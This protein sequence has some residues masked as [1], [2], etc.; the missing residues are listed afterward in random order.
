[1]LMNNIYQFLIYF[2]I[3]EHQNS[4]L[5]DPFLKRC[6]QRIIPKDV[7]QS[8]VEPDLTRFGA[9]VAGPIWYYFINVLREAFTCKYPRSANKN[10]SLTVFFALSGSSGLKAA[11]RPF[12]DEIDHLYGAIQSDSFFADFIL[13]RPPFPPHVQLENAPPPM[14][15]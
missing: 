13:T 9:A 11:L 8:H 14:W 6:L 5:S 10:D 1:M 4:F 7:Y 15:R 2:W 3:S 12:V